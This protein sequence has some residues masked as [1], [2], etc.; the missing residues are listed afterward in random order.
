LPG[1]LPAVSSSLPGAFQLMSTN[2]LVCNLEYPSVVKAVEAG[3][4]DQHCIDPQPVMLTPTPT[5]EHLS[6]GKNMIRTFTIGV[7][8]CC[9]C[10]QAHG[11]QSG[12]KEIFNGKDLTGWEGKANLWSVEEGAITGR[13][14]ADAPLKGNSFLVWKD[15]KVADF[16]LTLE[17]RVRAGDEKKPYGNS[18]IQYRSKL[19]DDKEFVVRGYQADIDLSLQYSGINYEEGGRGILA[20]RGQR[21]TIDASGKKSAESIGDAKALGEKIIKNEWNKYR[22][23]VKGNVLSHYINDTL[24]SETIDH[25]TEKAAKE[26]ILALQIHA[27]DP[28][29]IQFRKIMLKNN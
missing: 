11:Q 27:G 14:K 13:T 28:M 19:V 29:I 7:F 2:C 16:E 5:Y 1:S 18:G 4:L 24:M 12:F 22:L 25:Q 9:F 21:V 15:G 6:Q 23:V 20:E 10:V 26:G 17:Y 8:A 3:R